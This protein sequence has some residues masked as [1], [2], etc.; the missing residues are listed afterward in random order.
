M[1]LQL[2]FFHIDKELIHTFDYEV[3]QQFRMKNVSEFPFQPSNSEPIIEPE[4]LF[5][6]KCITLVQVNKC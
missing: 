2:I 3:L 1:H 5:S 4:A 6:T